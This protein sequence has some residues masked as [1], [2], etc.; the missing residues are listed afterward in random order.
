MSAAQLQ[1]PSQAIQARAF[2]QNPVSRTAYR[3]L[4]RTYLRGQGGQ[5]SIQEPRGRVAV[6][7][8]YSPHHMGQVNWVKV[9]QHM[10]QPI[11]QNTKPMV[12]STVSIGS[13]Q[14]QH[15]AADHAFPW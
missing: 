7:A 6:K 14:S 13:M 2:S 11:L 5:K 1:C 3:R 15:E 4:C 9:S 12:Q 8:G 10:L